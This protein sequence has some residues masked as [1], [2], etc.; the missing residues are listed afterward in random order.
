MNK[1][2]LISFML[3]LIVSICLISCSQGGIENIWNKYV[4]GVSE[5]NLEKITETFHD[6]DSNEYK[7]FIEENSNYF[8]II[9]SIKSKKFTKVMDCDFTSDLAK[10]AYYKA[11]VVAEV[12]G[13][14]KEFDLY[15]FLNDKG[16][17]F[18]TPITL[19]GDK[20]GNEPNDSWLAQVYYTNEDY[21]YS[22]ISNGETDS[23]KILRDISNKKEV[24]IPE[25]I[26]DKPVTE[27]GSYA[28]Y[29]YKKILCF[30]TR[31]SKMKK[32]S[33]PETLKTINS[34]AFFQCDE[35]E[36]L[37]LPKSL[38]DVKEMAFTGCR[39]LK[40]IKILRETEEDI[41]TKEIESD[42][43]GGG[44]KPL[45]IKGAKNMLQGE[46]IT[47]TTV[48]YPGDESLVTWS[49][50][51]TCISV[52]ADTGEVYASAKGE[53]VEIKVSLKSNPQVYATVKINVLPVEK[54]VKISGD[55]FNRCSSLESLYIYAYN[56]N[57]INVSSG[58]KYNL[59]SKTK[60]Y[61]P[62]GAKGM[63]LKSAVWS[64]YADQIYEME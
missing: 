39:G 56:P 1:K 15:M 35:L 30:T 18:T 34:Y 59:S 7:T 27:I 25:K 36:E 43:V 49:S 24:I 62:K 50:T 46:I 53:N 40:T 22:Y 45:I 32:L 16:Y 14:E 55:A 33:L 23:I 52:N 44:D 29:N 17:F 58:T 8:D 57:T 28:F 63:Y 10:Q 3:L 6:S 2:K 60:I 37:V 38:D 42:A 5:K 48:K 47:L 26:D 51:N 21:R 20:F 4:K 41:D 12:N 9:S 19:N 31:T 13:T 61:V 54:Y 11:N 64:S